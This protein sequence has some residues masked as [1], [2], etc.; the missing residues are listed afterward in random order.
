LF[1]DDISRPRPSSVIIGHDRQTAKVLQPAY[2]RPVSPV[3]SAT[4]LPYNFRFFVSSVF[5]NIV[6]IELERLMV[7]IGARPHGIVIILL[8]DRRRVGSCDWAVFELRDDTI[9]YTG[10]QNRYQLACSSVC[11]LREPIPLNQRSCSCGKVPAI[12]T[13]T[14][15]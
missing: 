12:K 11:R 3:I 7:G 10:L 9:G 8:T 4:G 15:F 5:V 1:L 13:K 6:R 14:K 2:L